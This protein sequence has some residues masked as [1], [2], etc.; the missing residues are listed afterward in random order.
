MAFLVH[1]NAIE[2]RQCHTIR[3]VGRLLIDYT[4][5]CLTQDA[6]DNRFG[7]CKYA[8]FLGNAQGNTVQIW[9]AGKKEIGVDGPNGKRP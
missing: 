4:C 6:A 5:P 1:D 8:Y 9:I 7:C 2:F 3:G